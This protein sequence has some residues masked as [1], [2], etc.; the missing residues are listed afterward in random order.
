MADHAQSTPPDS[1]ISPSASFYDLSDGEEGEYNTIM[2][3]TSGRGVKLLYSKSKVYVH[4]TPSSKDNIP[5][6]IALIQQKEPSSDRK[7]SSTSSSSTN[8]KASEYLLAWLPESSLGSS[9]EAYL[10]VDL[11]D[12]SSPPR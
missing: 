10:K 12:S 8:N 4:P 1:P 9:L 6:F 5:G 2:H 7:G 11:S 3:S